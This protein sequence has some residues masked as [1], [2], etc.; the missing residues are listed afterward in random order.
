VIIPGLKEQDYVHEKHEG[1]LVNGICRPEMR[2]RLIDIASALKERHNI[3]GLVLGASELPLILRD[4]SEIK[5]PLN[6]TQIHVNAALD[7]IL[8]QG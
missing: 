2:A 4:E 7:E 3:D 8:K 1:E 6:T 5:I